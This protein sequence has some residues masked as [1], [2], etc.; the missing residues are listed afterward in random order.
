[1]CGKLLLD[2]HD[3]KQPVLSPRIPHFQQ[4]QAHY[5]RF[6]ADQGEGPFFFRFFH[7]LTL[8]GCHLIY[9]FFPTPQQDSEIALRHQRNADAGFDFIQPKTEGEPTEKKPAYVYDIIETL[10]PSAAVG[11]QNPQG[12]RL[13]ELWARKDTPSRPGWTALVQISK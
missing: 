13:L 6:S 10:L 4:N 12:N 2:S 1:M 9:L 11:P 8:H 7:L 5:A 3:P